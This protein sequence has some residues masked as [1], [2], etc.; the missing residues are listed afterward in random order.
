MKVRTRPVQPDSILLAYSGGLDTSY[1]VAWLTRE[2]GFAVTTLTVD[3]GG[4]DEAEHDLLA[5]RALACGAQDHRVVDA[6]HMVFD[7]VVRWL[8]AGNV[9]RGATYPLCVSA[10]RGMQ[11]EILAKVAAADGF[12]AVAHGCTG[13]GNDQI[14]FEAALS[15][16]AS[17]G[18]DT[19]EVLAPIRDHAPSRAEEVAYLQAHGLG[20]PT[21]S[22]SY[23]INAGL[24]GL[25]VGGVETL[26]AS[27]PLPEC[28]WVWTKN[29]DLSSTRRFAVG[30]ERGIPTTLDGQTMD[31]VALI[32]TLNRT[33]GSLGVGRGYHI[34]DTV[35]GIKGRIGFEAPA[36]EILLSAH[37]ELEK[38]VLT[39]DQRVHKDLLAESYGR[40][41]HQGLLHDPFL[42]DAEALFASTQRRVT[43]TVQV[44]C[45]GGHAL[46]EGLSSPHDMLAASDARYGERPASDADPAAAVGLARALA[47][48]A[49][50]H[51][52][53][54]QQS[55][56]PR[57]EVTA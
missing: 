11:A 43:G 42:R 15:I 24:W 50:L 29:A 52:R 18:T 55:Q 39:E 54:G 27:G 23:S 49:R 14:R 41:L 48:P 56:Q 32:E 44:L 6:R 36:A 7:R 4:L 3:C 37:R 28:A 21:Q 13:A 46:V 31:P 20:V 16:V 5:E 9:R 17:K 22:G 2:R 53:A 38:L 47:T 8:I 1:L 45:R 57:A 33:A 40:R 25:T 10:E 35:L 12:E 34:G 19:L 51:S 30:F 26:D